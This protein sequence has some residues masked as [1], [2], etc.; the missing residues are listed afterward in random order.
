MNDF[1]TVIISDTHLGAKNCAAVKL[2]TFLNSIKTKQLILNGDIF[3]DLNFKRLDGAHFHC[4]RAIRKMSTTTDV[5]WISG[6]HDR[7]AGVL[8]HIMGIEVK[9][10][11][12][13]KLN[14]RTYYV[15]HGDVFDEILRKHPI[16]TLV[17][18]MAYR[19][20]QVFDRSHNFALFLKRK[21]KRFTRSYDKVKRRCVDL[22]KRRGFYGIMIGHLHIPESA[23]IEGVHYVN[24]GSWTQ[25]ACTFIGIKNDQVQVYDF[26]DFYNTLKED[27]KSQRNIAL[28]S[29]KYA[30][31]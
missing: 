3:D 7:A 25:E 28:L 30:I 9:A 16:L 17:A 6:N 12:K 8:S 13:L 21:C 1:D 14:G 24:S 19:L 5:V 18:D 10:S 29:E 4:L 23:M 2:R 15:L 11:L 22:A 27:K 31:A 26:D 20:I